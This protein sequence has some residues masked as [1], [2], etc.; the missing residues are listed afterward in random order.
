MS[1]KGFHIVF[2]VVSTLLAFGIGV[3]CLWVNS[4]AATT[5]TYTLGAVCSF[6]AALVLVDL[7]LLVL[8]QNEAASFDLMKA[9]LTLPA[10]RSCLSR[11]SAKPWPVPPAWPTRI[12]KPPRT[13]RS[14][15][16]S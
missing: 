7:W 10:R 16:G 13:W 2:I 5:P 4:M 3:W 14:Q 8:A 1:L 12:R 9:K 11:P 6:V 15:S